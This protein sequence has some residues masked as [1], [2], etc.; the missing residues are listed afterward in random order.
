MIGKT[1]LYN[2][3]VEV[4]PLDSWGCST[5]ESDEVEMTLTKPYQYD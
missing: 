2:V 3:E 1:T 5:R 4:N